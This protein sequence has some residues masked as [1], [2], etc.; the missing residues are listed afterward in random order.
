MK[1]NKC[2]SRKRV[3]LRDM[4]ANSQN[5]ILNQNEIAEITDTF[6]RNT[7]IHGMR[8]IGQRNRP[9]FER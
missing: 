7:S 8:Y 2:L 3:S 1:R 5:K 6:L 4:Y 9:I